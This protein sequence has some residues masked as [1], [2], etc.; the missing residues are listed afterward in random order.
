MEQYLI[1]LSSVI[2][3]SLNGNGRNTC[4]SN[5]N[6][7]IKFHSHVRAYTC[8]S[9]IRVIVSFV[10][11]FVPKKANKYRETR[12]EVTFKNSTKRP[13]VAPS[14]FPAARKGDEG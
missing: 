4:D 2:C 7:L 9:A 8:T 12:V 3:T 6:I 13:G 10:D 1:S 11:G 5:T 14:G